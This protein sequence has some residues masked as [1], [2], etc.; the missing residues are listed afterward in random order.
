LL[1]SSHLSDDGH[2][3]IFNTEYLQPLDIISKID[4]FCKVKDTAQVETDLALTKMSGKPKK[5][6]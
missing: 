3:L 6:K 5:K 2:K 4:E 1:L